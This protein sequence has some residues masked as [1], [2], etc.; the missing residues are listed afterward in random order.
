MED[1]CDRG[2]SNL[3]KIV[4]SMITVILEETIRLSIRVKFCFEEKHCSVLN[5]CPTY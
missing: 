4:N 5:K 2:T 3:E 1:L